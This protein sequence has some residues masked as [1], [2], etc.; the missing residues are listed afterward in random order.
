MIKP[1]LKPDGVVE[2]A[3]SGCCC[4]PGPKRQG[5]HTRGFTFWWR[6]QGLFWNKSPGYTARQLMGCAAVA[7]TC[8]EFV[9]AIESGAL[10]TEDELAEAFLDAVLRTTGPETTNS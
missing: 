1:Y 9:K 8:A 10:P 3:S 5:L 2:V 4:P 7:K 6:T